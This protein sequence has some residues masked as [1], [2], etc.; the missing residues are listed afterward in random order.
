MRQA[1]DH[2]KAKGVDLSRILYQTPV[3]KGV[4]LWNTERQDH[5]LEAALDHDLIAAATPAG[6]R[7]AKSAASTTAVARVAASCAAFTSRSRSNG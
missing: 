5:G 3:E 6:R 4:A 2:Y 7:S 1:I